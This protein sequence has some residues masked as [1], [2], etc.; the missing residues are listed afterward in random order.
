MGESL[1]WFMAALI[2]GIY[3]TL[4]KIWSIFRDDF[5]NKPLFEDEDFSKYTPTHHVARKAKP[6][7]PNYRRSWQVSGTRP[8]RFAFL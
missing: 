6:S 1:S 3:L 2:L 8:P 7:F 5:W 4:I